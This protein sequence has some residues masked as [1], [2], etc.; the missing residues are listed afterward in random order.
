MRVARRGCFTFFALLSV[1]E[2]TENEAKEVKVTGFPTLLFFGK[3]ATEAEK[4]SGGA[5]IMPCTCEDWGRCH[6]LSTHTRA[7]ETNKRK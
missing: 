6:L 3:G 7:Q 4:Y 2:G 5:C 1:C